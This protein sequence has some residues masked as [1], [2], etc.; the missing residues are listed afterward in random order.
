MSDFNLRRESIEEI[1]DYNVLISEFENGDEQRR[2][3]NPAPV[4][5]F[6]I[7]TPILTKEQMQEYR[8]FMTENYGAYDSFTFTSPF[9]DVEYNVRFVPDSFKTT[10]SEG[11]FK[12]EFQLKVVTL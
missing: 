10:Y 5:G 9:D 1:L 4:I 6:V 2:L 3:K 7:K 11:V 8:D 12:C